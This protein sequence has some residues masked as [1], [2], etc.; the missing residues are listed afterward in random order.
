[1]D[2]LPGENLLAIP[3]VVIDQGGGVTFTLV[4]RETTIREAVEELE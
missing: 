3:P 2:P 1:V 4:G